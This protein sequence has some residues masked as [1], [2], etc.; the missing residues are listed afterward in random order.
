MGKRIWIVLIGA[1]LL[2]LLVVTAACGATGGQPAGGGATGQPAGGGGVPANPGKQLVEERCTVCHGI[3]RVTAAQKT[4]SE[5]Q[6]TVERM[7]AHGAQLDS[8]QQSQ[9]INY[10]AEAYPK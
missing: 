1:A 8:S 4:Q 10:L 7:V 3:E 2:L 6:A 9:V 5:W